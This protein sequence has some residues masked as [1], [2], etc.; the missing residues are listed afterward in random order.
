[1]FGAIAEFFEEHPILGTIGALITLS[2]GKKAITGQGLVAPSTVTETLV[3]GE[4]STLNLAAG[5]SA[6]LDLATQSA[7]SVTSSDPTTVQVTQG[8]GPQIA[9]KA[10]KSGTATLHV[11]FVADPNLGGATPAPA[12]MTVTVP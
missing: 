10:L 4:T 1:V 8:T 5:S 7:A 9:V 12:T 6:N 11:T 2:A 3:S